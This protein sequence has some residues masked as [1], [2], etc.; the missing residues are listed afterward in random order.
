MANR[1]YHRLLLL[2]Q[3]ELPD[4]YTMIVLRRT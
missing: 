3:F 2:S 4:D 1:L